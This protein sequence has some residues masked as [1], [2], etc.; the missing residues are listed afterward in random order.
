MPPHRTPIICL[1]LLALSV[2]LAAVTGSVPGSWSALGPDG[3]SILELV[4]QPG[5]PQVLYAGSWG[6]AYKSV[7]GGATWSRIS[8]GLQLLSPVSSLAVDPIHPSTVY[9]GQETGLYKSLDGGS[10][11]RR[12][13]LGFAVLRVAVHP[14]FPQTVYA[15]TDRGLYQTANGGTRWKRLTRGLLPL[16]HSAQGVFI[17]PASPNRLF[18]SVQDNLAAH[19][20]LYKSV[21]GGF[22]WQPVHSGVM[23]NQV[24]RSL[25]IDRRPPATLFAGTP[26]GVYK[27]T[28]DG[29]T[30]RRS[31]DPSLGSILSL[32]LNPVDK[33]VLY[34][35]GDAGLFRSLDR[36]ET[37][38]R[39][40]HNLPDGG[41][42]TA[43]LLSPSSP[44]ILYV[45][46][47]GF[48]NQTGVFRS[49]DGGSSWTLSSRGISGYTVPSVAVD[50]Q[51]PDVLWVIANNLPYKSVDRG[52]SWALIDPGPPPLGAPYLVGVAVSPADPQTVYLH[53]FDGTILRS[54]D[55]G[56]TWVTAGNPG[57]TT[58]VLKVDPQNPDTLWLAGQGIAKST[59]GGDTWTLLVR[60]G[61]YPVLAIAPSSPSTVYVFGDLLG[62]PRFLRTNDGGATGTTILENLPARPST[63]AIDP[64]LPQTLYTFST[65]GE[66]YKSVDGGTT[67]T[68]VSNV[69]RKKTVPSLIA[70]SSGVL[71]AGVAWDDV[72]ESVDGGL[73]WSPLGDD[74]RPSY[75]AALA[76]DPKDP[77][78]VYAGTGGGIYDRGLLAFTK[79]GT[80]AC[81]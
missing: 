75:F 50:A 19:G 72:Y 20:G 44:Q 5:N 4:F 47:K 40:A 52:R 9:A 32:T 29:R 45:G 14:R 11:W 12:T 33:N 21:D 62:Q 60:D 69:F 57:I 59:D 46:V 66:L 77:C 24:V 73:S 36:G 54:R 27:S 26:T 65:L 63:L 17:D 22:S 6:E 70:A 18:V 43:V 15:A 74:S 81:P 56:Q 55:G 31:G 53:R 34:A 67:W 2:P 37:W 10:T 41:S 8:R 3:G 35:G 16:P 13:A 38:V 68:L 25:A 51:N 78:R 28:D 7:N 61:F 80:P 42:V 1:L 71:Y 23:E 76:E 39:L 48:R 64:L 30:W 79:T 58:T 49:G